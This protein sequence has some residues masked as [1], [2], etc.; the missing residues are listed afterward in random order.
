M[1]ITIAK[2]VTPVTTTSGPGS[3]FSEFDSA[4][5]II[6]DIDPNMALR[7]KYLDRLELTIRAAAAGVTT[8]KPTNRVP[9]T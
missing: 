6:A 9:V 4:I 2:I 8:R 5:P 1:I 3:M 7:V